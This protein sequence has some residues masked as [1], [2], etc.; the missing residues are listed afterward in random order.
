MMTLS[1][2]GRERKV[3]EH[4]PREVPFGERVALMVTR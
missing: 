1:P 3:R 4:E 2:Q